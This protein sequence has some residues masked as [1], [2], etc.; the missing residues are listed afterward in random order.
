MPP[1][2]EAAPLARLT[3]EISWDGGESVGAGRPARLSMLAQEAASRPARSG[4]QPRA[5]KASLRVT[6]EDTAGR[7]VSQTVVDA[8]AV[9]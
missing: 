4:R 5:G 3:V 6:A 9:E 8:Y 7:T 1:E 2:V